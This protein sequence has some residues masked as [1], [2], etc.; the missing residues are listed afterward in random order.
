MAKLIYSMITSLDGYITD[1]DGN[2]D[3][4]EPDA[5]VFEATLNLERAVGTV[6]YGRRMYEMMVYWETF[7]RTKDEPAFLEEFADNWRAQT[8]IV[9]STTLERASS[10]NTFIERAF[11]PEAVREMKRS[12]ERDLSIGG[13]HLAS[14]AI[15]ARL[16]DEMDVFVVPITVGGGTPAHPGEVHTKLEL[17]DTNTFESGFVH[18]HYRVAK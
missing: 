7:S 13:A 10:A 8:K 3:W 11:I 1:A 2:F 16:V 18:L 5:E 14:Q 12:S 17:L 6:L 4:A 9:Y 15:E